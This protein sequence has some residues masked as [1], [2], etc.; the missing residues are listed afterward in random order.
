MARRPPKKR[1]NFDD[2]AVKSILF[3]LLAEF[4]QKGL[5]ASDLHSTYQGLA[6]AQLKRDCLAGGDISG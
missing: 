3:A 6:P 1:V 2:D 4:K 5:G